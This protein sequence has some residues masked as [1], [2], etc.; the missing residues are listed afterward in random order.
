MTRERSHALHINTQAN[1][2][3]YQVD[4]L[5]EHRVIHGQVYGTLSMSD[6]RKGCEVAAALFDQSSERTY[7]IIRIANLT[8][9]DFDLGLIA[10]ASSILRHPSL[11]RWFTYDNRNPMYYYLGRMLGRMT[12]TH[13]DMTDTL[14]EAVELLYKL[15]PTLG[16]VQNPN[17][18]MHP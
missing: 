2:M 4:W 13:F 17:H 10:E 14:D 16:R 3:P 15:D 5:I 9:T 1:P 8:L 18:T 6:I 11:E 7:L 12:G